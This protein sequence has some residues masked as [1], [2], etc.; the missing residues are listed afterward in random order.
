[1]NYCLHCSK[2]IITPD[3]RNRCS[4]DFTQYVMLES[5]DKY[6]E[7]P[8]KIWMPEKHTLKSLPK[9]QPPKKTKKNVDSV[10]FFVI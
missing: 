5:C 7:G 3:G 2:G 4:L 1:M 9:P 8:L 10:S 6:V